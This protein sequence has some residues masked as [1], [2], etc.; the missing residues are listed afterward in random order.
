MRLDS[1]SKGIRTNTPVDPQRK[2]KGKREVPILRPA[3]FMGMEGTTAEDGSKKTS[4][5][6][7]RYHIGR[8]MTNRFKLVRGSE[9]AF[10]VTPVLRNRR[11]DI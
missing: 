9:P 8:L 5:F 6:Y 7:Y 4:N 11:E 2:K 3:T 10:S 1:V